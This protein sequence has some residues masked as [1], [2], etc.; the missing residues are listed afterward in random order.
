MASMIAINYNVYSQDL[1]GK[2]TTGYQGWFA[3]PNNSSSSLPY[4]KWFHWGTSGSNPNDL[5]D[6]PFFENG[7]RKGV[8]FDLYPDI[9][10]YVKNGASLHDSGLG[11]HE[12]SES[13]NGNITSNA[14]LFSSAD[15]I[16]TNTHLGWMQDNNIDVVAIQ[17]FAN[18]IAHND[19]NL[20]SSKK[21]HRNQVLNNFKNSAS[22]YGRKFYVMYDISGLEDMEDSNNQPLYNDSNWVNVIK[23]DWDNVINVNNTLTNSSGYAKEIV[24]RSVGAGTSKP[25][26]CLWGF[27]EVGR[28]GNSASYKNL[29]KFF[30][31]RGY[32][33]VLGVYKK[34]YQEQSN[35]FSAFK[36]ADMISP[37]YVGSFG[38]G[39]NGTDVNNFYTNTVRPQMNW[40]N[41]TANNLDFMPVLWAGF[42][43]YNLKGTDFKK[44][45]RREGNLLWRQ[46][47]NAK[48]QFEDFSNIKNNP[49]IYIAM[50]DE[51]DE[52]TAIMKAANKDAMIPNNNSTSLNNGLKFLK[53]ENVS[54]DFY[55][56]VVKDGRDMMN[57]ITSL[58]TT[59]PTAPYANTKVF[60]EEVESKTDWNPNSSLVLS[61]DREVGDKSI[62]FDNHSG[63]VEFQKTLTTALDTK[64]SKSNGALYFWYQVT[65]NTN[66][67]NVYV[68]IRDEGSPGDAQE[69]QWNITGLVKNNWKKV[70]LRLNTNES[71]TVDLSK[72]NYFRI[73]NSAGSSVNR[74][75]RLDD[76]WF[77]LAAASKRNQKKNSEVSFSET[78][79]IYPNPARD[80]IQ[81]NI[82]QNRT[83]NAS[84]IIYDLKGR[85][86]H[87]E[88]H[89]ALDEFEFRINT[90]SLQ[91]GLYIL[92]IDLDNKTQ[93]KKITIK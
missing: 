14:E 79:N 87:K 56:R 68:E 69:Y 32:Y 5:R 66:I 23:H 8:T 70:K 44:H 88:K 62:K 9:T 4:Q 37:W 38:W 51:V 35:L 60:F 78:I 39:S 77:E 91:S 7:N 58:T 67:N 46:F 48:N 90:T 1:K 2:V 12:L 92:K 13:V 36:K 57:G 71:G 63:H 27:G 17:R 64:Q 89:K 34:F 30:K 54:P 10:D 41:Q 84:F 50:F 42:S 73:L 16:I 83:K 3:T 52:G 59:R 11:S 47:Y 82:H 86:V 93:I 85:S 6:E 55:M 49:P 20:N 15:H 45:E 21:A 19:P 61:S 80:F 31:D 53:Y 29:I 18:E 74:T 43:W 40:C 75:T 25:V 65:R 24:K 81:V 33:V 76:I 26:I 72:I 28:I 22:T